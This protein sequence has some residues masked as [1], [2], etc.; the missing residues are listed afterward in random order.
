[1]YQ[2]RDNY[3]STRLTLDLEGYCNKLGISY[4][5]NFKDPIERSA[6]S[7]N[8]FAGKKFTWMANSA[9]A[10]GVLH[11]HPV[12]TPQ[13]QTTWEEWFIHSDGLHHHVLRNYIFDDATD[14]WLGEDPDHPAE[15]C[16]IQWHLY[17]DTDMRPLDLR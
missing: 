15:V 17:N 6:S 11:L 14:S 16:N 3:L 1:M 4:N 5:I 12:D 8:P 7:V 13:A 2:S 9:I 10:F